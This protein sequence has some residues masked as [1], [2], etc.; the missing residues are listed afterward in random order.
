M[1]RVRGKV[2]T[3]ERTGAWDERHHVAYVTRQAQRVNMASV[4]LSSE[5]MT[6]YDVQVWYFLTYTET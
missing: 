6:M 3:R 1:G 2:R 5:A 4:Y